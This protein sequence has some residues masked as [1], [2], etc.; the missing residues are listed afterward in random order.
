M[1]IFVCESVRSH[2]FYVIASHNDCMPH[3]ITYMDIKY[4]G[5]TPNP[6][7]YLHDISWAMSDSIL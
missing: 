5:R 6:Y 3:D 7:N 4:F 1:N 2:K